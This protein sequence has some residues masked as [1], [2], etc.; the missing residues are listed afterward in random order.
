MKDISPRLIADAHEARRHSYSPYS[1]FAVGAALLTAGGTIYTGCNV[2][3]AAYGLTICAE[4]VAL[5]KAIS[6]G[7]R[8]FRAIGVVGP[9]PGLSPCGSCRQAL[10]EFAPGL[11]VF[12]EG[13][14]GTIVEWPLRDLLPHPFESSR[15]ES[16]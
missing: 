4:R 13:P 16:L 7:E 3:N 5:C 8:E 10:W 6:E 1:E 2:E 14:D 15:F 12:A 9:E 11:M